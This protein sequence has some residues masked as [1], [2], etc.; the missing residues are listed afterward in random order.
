MTQFPHILAI[1][2]KNG[3]SMEDYAQIYRVK[4][5]EKALTKMFKNR[6]LYRELM[7]S[8]TAESSKPVF[9]EKLFKF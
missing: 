4:E 1:E 9:L 3:I 2:E 6:V 5:F 8:R 7:I